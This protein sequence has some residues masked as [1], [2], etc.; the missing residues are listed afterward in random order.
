MNNKGYGQLRVKQPDGQWKSRL[1]HVVAY[2]EAKGPMPAGLETDHLCRITDCVNPD[3]L[4]AVTHSE[5][6]RRAVAPDG[7]CA[8]GHELAGPNLHVLPDGRRRCRTCHARR[9]AERR[10]RRTPEQIER[11]RQSKRRYKQK[12]KEADHHRQERSSWS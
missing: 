1:A 4:E 5:N 9:E 10:P 2:E 3:H 12:M 6:M 8:R 11:D 7:R